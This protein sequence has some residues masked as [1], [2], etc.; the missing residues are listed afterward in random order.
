MFS[1]KNLTIML[2]VAIAALSYQTYALAALSEKV[3][4]AQIG[5]GSA[6]AEVNFTDTGG[7]AP[8][9]VGGC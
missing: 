8:D 2:V 3:D 9:M 1:P 4:E 6:S 5:F 7:E